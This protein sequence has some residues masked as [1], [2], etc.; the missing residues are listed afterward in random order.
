MLNGNDERG[1]DASAPQKGGSEQPWGLALAPVEK[2]EDRDRHQR[3]SAVER[4]SARK[5]TAAISAPML[6]NALK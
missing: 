6:E 2:P 4:A 1:G 3:D 5:N